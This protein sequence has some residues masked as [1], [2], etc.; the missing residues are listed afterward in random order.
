MQNPFIL[1]EEHYQR[2]LNIIEGYH[3]DAARYLH[4][5]TGQPLDV[6][7]SFVKDQTRPQKTQGFNDPR[8]LVIVKDRNGDRRRA[9]ASFMR[10]LKRVEKENLLLS[11]SMAAY[12]PETRAQSTHAL[13]IEEGVRARKRVKGE[14]FQAQREANQAQVAGDLVTARQKK[15]LA[16]MKNG[17]QNNLKINNNSYS[18][19]TCSPATILYYKSTHSSL[20][21]TCRTAT[22]YANAN[23]E[24][25]LAGNRHYYSP[26][27][28]KANLL[29]IISAADLDKVQKACDQF[30]LH[31]P[32]AEDLVACVRH[33]SDL[34]WQGEG[35]IEKIRRMALAMTP[36]ERA[37][38][39]Y[40]SDLFHLHKHNPDFVTQFLL[41]LA[42]PGDAAMTISD[43]EFKGYDDDVK[44]LANLLCFEGVQGRDLGVLKDQNPE[45]YDQVKATARRIVEVLN[46][47]RPLVEA[48]WLTRSVPSSIHAFPTAYRKAA[49][50]SDT[51]STMFTLQYWVEQCFGK[52]S[53]SPQAKQVVF[54][55]VFLVSEVVMHILAL[56]S[57]NMGVSKKKLRLLA[58]KN[59][60][61]FAVLSLTTRSKHYYASRDAQEGLF[62]PVPELEVKGVGLRD[63]KVPPQINRG[64]KELM[65]EIIATV[66]AE[67]ELDMRSILKRVADVERDITRSLLAGS[68]EYLSTG[69]IKTQDSYKNA[70]NATYMQYE[71]WRD[72]FGPFLGETKEPPYSIVKVSLV[73]NNRTEV[74]A[75]CERMNNPALA[76]RLKAWLAERKRKD[77][78]TL[79]IPA[80]V[81]ETSGVPPEIIAG[82]DTRKVIS[83]IMG[84]YYLILE[85]LGI[86]LQDSKTVRL[87]SDYY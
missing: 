21:S 33:S 5:Q 23:N 42:K 11:P 62:K 76:T 4:L 73:A 32:S 48:F 13:Y 29:A 43:E 18:G 37:A 57:A 8:A 86:F 59:E 27:I 30:G 52:V 39:L 61:Y 12:L 54:A 9:G 55:V 46:H 70:D 3:Q 14:M 68:P 6:C 84:A 74:E 58:M 1:P 56:Q 22:S 50:I 15:E 44:M 31:Y 51:D 71:L 10:F 78:S 20:T 25:F 38:I 63:S 67:Q 28:T 45:I 64:A 49:V 40:V 87:L 77:L 69:Q 60:F 36:V 65:E 72:V 16:A 24:K 82:L 7:L 53:Y 80:T 83:N 26:E 79:M 47:Y 85:S 66:K 17:E 2:D 34:Y 75:W 41:E 81:V 35:H 19:A